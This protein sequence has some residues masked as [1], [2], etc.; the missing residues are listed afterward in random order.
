ME[1]I[2]KILKKKRL[3]LQVLEETQK[4]Y[5]YLPK[6]ALKHISKKLNIPLSKVY[7]T[8]TFYFLFEV[9]RRGKYLIRVCNSPPCYI[10]GSLNILEFLKKEL[11]IDVCET[12]KNKK[13]SLELTSCIGCC[14]E[15]PAMMINDKV[16]C[17]LTEEKIKKILKKLK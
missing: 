17:N 8:A 1:K 2:D 12:T 4:E 13:F 6:P 10:N 16:Y 9:K 14:D 15:A 7:G 3:L 5:G 11:K